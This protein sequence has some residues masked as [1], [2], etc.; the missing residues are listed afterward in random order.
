[1]TS[2]HLVNTTSIQEVSNSTPG[3]RTLTSD[4]LVDGNIYKFLCSIEGGEF[5]G[6][7]VYIGGIYRFYQA[8][9][10]PFPGGSELGSIMALDSNADIIEDFNTDI[11]FQIALNPN[12]FTDIYEITAISGNRIACGGSQNL[13]KNVPTTNGLAILY[14][15]GA[16]DTTFNTSIGSPNGRIFAIA[17][18]PSTEILY[19][20]GEFQYWDQGPLGGTSNPYTASPYMVAL[21]GE[22]GS[23]ITGFTALFDGAPGDNF[24]Y[25]SK[26]RIYNGK[27]YVA[28]S[29]QTYDGET[30][31]GIVRLNMDG[32]LDGSW[33]PSGVGTNWT[34]IGDNGIVQDFCFY[35]NYIY[36]LGY[37]TSY[38]GTARNSIA[39]LNL[40][41]GTLD[42]SWNPGTGLNVS[43]AYTGYG[44]ITVDATGVYVGSN[45]TQYNGTTSTG[46]VKINHDATINATFDVGAGFTQTGGSFR[47][48]GDVELNGDGSLYVVGVFDLY[49]GVASRG[50]AKLN[51]TTG[52]M[53]ISPFDVGGFG[54]RNGTSLI[55]KGAVPQFLTYEF[56]LCYG[57]ESPCVAYCCDNGS[58]S[59]WGNAPSLTTSTILYSN[60]TGTTFASPGYYSDGTSIAQVSSNG[61]IIAFVNPAGCTCET[62]VKQFNVVYD[63]CN[64]VSLIEEVIAPTPQ[65][66]ANNFFGV[67]FTLN[68]WP[69]DEDVTITGYLRDD[70]NITNTYEFVL[71]IPAGQQS[72]ETAN[73]VLMTGP[74][75]TATIFI[76][77]ITPT[78]VTYDGQLVPICGLAPEGPCCTVCCGIPNTN[79]YSNSQAWSTTTILYSNSGASTFASPGFYNFAGIVLTIGSNG[80]VTAVNTCD[81]ECP[82]EA[83]YVWII[84]NNSGESQAS[85]SYTDC[86][87]TPRFGS[88]NPLTATITTCTTYSSLTVTGDVSIDLDQ[89]CVN[90]IDVINVFGYMEPCIGGTID[91]Y[92]GA[93]I[94]LNAPV[95]VE[96][97]F[98]VEVK[99][100]FPGA[101]CNPSIFQSQY[102]QLV[103]PAGEQ[104]SN[105]IACQNGAYFSGGATICSACVNS[106]YN[107][108][109]DVI[110]LGSASC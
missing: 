92:M 84:N 20:G 87:G 10:W 90:E 9:G 76:T 91:D 40:S 29:F 4:I 78:E 45:F 32:T 43:G 54:I 95:T 67:K 100:A 46:L 18:D 62:T 28:G 17:E 8:I 74:A 82:I 5:T 36:I 55:I 106:Y 68:P 57:T 27:I 71:T 66:G 14:E 77:N 51:A 37:F 93:Q 109:V 80:V 103:V 6:D 59:V 30:K 72:V 53:E 16:L 73:N 83:C 107:N 88:L 85:Y 2:E 99:F 102:F 1:M 96:T 41:D 75:D 104:S 110:N 22:N 70:G 101:Q 60:S 21:N 24:G 86:S 44:A 47:I 61:V 38:N 63:E 35:N 97:T 64:C 58:A 48:I 69:V 89:S 34:S 12:P 52:V 33:N 11:G 81:C 98:D 108:T 79:V 13:Y 23:I 25:I 42:T 26:I 19:V 94:Y 65:T 15:N 7:K 3:S 39:R 105:F 31:S 50:I 56:S 49:K